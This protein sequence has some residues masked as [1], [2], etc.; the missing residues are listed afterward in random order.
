M[1]IIMLMLTIMIIIF[2]LV[3]SVYGQK[4]GAARDCGG[5]GPYVPPYN[6]QVM[7]MMVILKMMIMKMHDDYDDYDVPP[8]NPQVMMM[9]AMMNVVM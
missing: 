3:R 4:P 8:Y 1:M 5:Q 7:M 9:M 6:P 2:D